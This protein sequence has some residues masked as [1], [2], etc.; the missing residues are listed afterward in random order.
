MARFGSAGS[1]TDDYCDLLARRVIL[2]RFAIPEEI[3]HYRLARIQNSATVLTWAST[4]RA[5]IR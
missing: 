1:A 5:R 4:L 3:D 2:A